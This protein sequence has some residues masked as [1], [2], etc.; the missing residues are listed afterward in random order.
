MKHDKQFLP[1][2]KIPLTSDSKYCNL[3][4]LRGPDEPSEICKQTLQSLISVK[5]NVSNLY[6]DQNMCRNYLHLF[7]SLNVK[8]YPYLGNEVPI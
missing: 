2:H 5:L 6:L 7:E 8:I 3:I 1:L 4:V